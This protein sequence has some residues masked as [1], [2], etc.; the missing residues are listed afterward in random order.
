LGAES[1]IVGDNACVV[2]PGLWHVICGLSSG[3][4]HFTQSRGGAKGKKMFFFATLRLCEKNYFT[5]RRQA[6]KGGH[7]IFGKS[8][9]AGIAAFFIPQA[10]LPGIVGRMIIRPYTWN[11]GLDG[12]NGSGRLSESGFSGFQ[13]FQDYGR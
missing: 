2:L 11:W 5:Q 3:K 8:T 13:D 9:G 7:S 1:G 12:G 10:V 4:N 6:A